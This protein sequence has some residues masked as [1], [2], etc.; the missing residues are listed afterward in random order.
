MEY[1]F[2]AQTGIKVSCLCLGAMTFGRETDKKT[3]FS[4][5]NKFIEAGGNFIDTADVYSN[6]LSEEIIGEWLKDRNRDEIVI[7]TK[8]RFKMSEGLNDIGLSRKHILAS[9]DAS[10]KRLK[11]DYIDLY[12]IHAWDNKTSIE[13]TLDALDYTVKSGRVRYSGASNLKAWQ[14]QKAIDVSK[15]NRW[16]KFCALQSMYNLLE[17]GIELEVED[18]IK[19]ENLA[20][21]PWSPLRG[22]W[23]SGKFQRGMSDAPDNSRIKVAKEK[24]WSESWDAYN[25]KHTWKVVD[26]LVSISKAIGKPPSVVAINWLLQ[27]EIVTSPII[28]ART[29]EQLVINLGATDWDLDKELVDR[30]DK[31]SNLNFPFYPYSENYKNKYIRD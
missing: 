14:L 26:E 10:L 4:I 12:Q 9:V 28:G 19:N 17:R 23:L 31:I 1:K 2:F 27:K 16:A 8:V 5:L 22:G 25:N 24:G 3:S 11:T 15:E 7:A 30:L 29:M 20:F 13:E 18:V 6:G 21:I